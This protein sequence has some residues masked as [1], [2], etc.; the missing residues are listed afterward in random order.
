MKHLVLVLCLAFGWSTAEA[1]VAIGQHTYVSAGNFV[2]TATTTATGSP[3]TTGSTCVVIE[4]ASQ[5]YAGAGSAISD[6]GSNTWTHEVADFSFAGGGRYL[7]AWVSSNCTGHSAETV[8]IV[9]GGGYGSISIAFIEITGAATASLDANPTPTSGTVTTTLTGPSSGT[10]ATTG[11]MVI[12]IFAQD[13][14]NTFSAPTNSYTLGDQTAYTTTIGIVWSYLIDS[15]TTST[16]TGVT[17]SS[18]VNY[19]GALLSFK[20]GGASCSHAGYT[21]GGAI[22]TPNGSSGS[23]VGKAGAFVTPNCSSVNYWQPAVGNFGQLNRSLSFPSARF[24]SWPA[25]AAAAVRQ[26]YDNMTGSSP[27]FSPFVYNV[28]AFPSTNVLVG[29]NIVL[30]ITYPNDVSSK[31]VSGVTDTNGDS[32]SQLDTE[33]DSTGGQWIAS[34]VCLNV[35]A[36]SSSDT[37]SVHI[38]ITGTP[39]YSS[40]YVGTSL[41]EVTGAQSSVLAHHGNSQTNVANTANA[42]TS[43]SLANGAVAGLLVAAPRITH[44]MVRHPTTPRSEPASPSSAREN[45]GGSNDDATFEYL[46][47]SSLGTLAATFTSPTNG[48]DDFITAAVAFEDTGGASCSHAGYTSAGQSPLR[49]DPQELCRESWRFR[50]AQLFQRQLLATGRRNFGTN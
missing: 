22:A 7:N 49:T 10:L 19:A 2:N 9:N 28:S 14:S 27:Q 25:H 5:P 42:I 32:C 34:W 39:D 46:H 37:I 12:G 24:R 48:I 13:N 45:S 47:S 17:A 50:Y 36:M 16:S 3:T 21:S 41:V 33:L 6:L 35:A 1:A 23:Y 18:N 44:K 15:T 26:F 11:E 20:P 40:D 29:S 30:W 38:G 31:Y 43:G 8:T 4:G